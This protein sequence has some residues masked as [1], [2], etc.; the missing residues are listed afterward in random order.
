MENHSIANNNNNK[1]NDNIQDINQ[2]SNITQKSNERFNFFPTEIKELTTL[3]SRKL[4]LN[5]KRKKIKVYTKQEQLENRFKNTKDAKENWKQY[6][7]AAGK[8]WVDDTLKD[9][10]ED[11]YRIFVGD[12]GNDVKDDELK[13]AFSNYNS[14]LKAKVVRDSRTGKSKGYGFVS[15]ETAD[16]YIKAM[17]E[18]KNKYIGNRPVKLERSKWK[19]R[20]VKYS[21]SKLKAS[22]FI[23]P[24]KDDGSVSKNINTDGINGNFNTNINTR[25]SYN[26]NIN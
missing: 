22:T 7:K 14:L 17:K 8:I 2:S 25:I 24:K 6:R 3:E 4:I 16:D 18:M 20:S 13:A 19:N 15:F 12:L 26:N 23:K 11:D 10:K 9:W 1:D 21:T 5:K